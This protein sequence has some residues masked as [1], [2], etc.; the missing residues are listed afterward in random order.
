MEQALPVRSEW[1]NFNRL[2]MR[3]ERTVPLGPYN[4]LLCGKG[5]HGTRARER[6]ETAVSG[7][8]RAEMT[9]HEFSCIF[10]IFLSGHAPNL[11]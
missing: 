4:L 2:R 11:W 1:L 7:S 8:R 5:V 3:V 6:C 9:C 10:G